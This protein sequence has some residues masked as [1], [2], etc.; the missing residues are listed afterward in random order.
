MEPIFTEL[1]L[2]RQV[3]ENKFYGEFHENPT[4][5]LGIWSLMLYLRW[6]DGI[7]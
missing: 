3:L 2:D 1:V 5:N 6:T 4:N 7:K